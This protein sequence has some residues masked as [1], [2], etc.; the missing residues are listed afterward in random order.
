VIDT[1]PVAWLLVAA[2]HRVVRCHCRTRRSHPGSFDPKPPHLDDRN[3]KA[4]VTGLPRGARIPKTMTRS[5][6]PAADLP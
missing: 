2:I 4:Q 6:L 1:Q 3:E 5:W